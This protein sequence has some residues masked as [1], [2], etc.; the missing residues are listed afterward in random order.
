MKKGIKNI[1]A[2]AYKLKLA[3]IKATNHKLEVAKKESQKR[4][5]M[6]KRE[7]TKAM[8]TKY[9]NPRGK[10][11]YLMKRRKIIKITPEMK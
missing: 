6:I 7:K 9:Q 5:E 4:E 10:L 8:A 1:Y 11:L 3:S 2:I